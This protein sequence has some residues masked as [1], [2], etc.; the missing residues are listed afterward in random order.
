MVNSFRSY[1]ITILAQFGF[2][3]SSSRECFELFLAMTASKMALAA[4]LALSFAASF[5]AW[6][7]GSWPSLRQS[8]WLQ[9]SFPSSLGLLASLV[10]LF[11]EGVQ[12]ASPQG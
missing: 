7:W 9:G 11:S 10:L 1:A 12:L 8:D 2:F 6:R 3:S 5:A 4:A